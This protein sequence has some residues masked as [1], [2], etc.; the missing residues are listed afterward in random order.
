MCTFRRQE[1]LF[2]AL[3]DAVQRG[4]FHEAGSLLSQHK[5]ESQQLLSNPA[6]SARRQAQ[7]L[8]SMA[9]SVKGLSASD[10]AVLPELLRRLCGKGLS[11]L[12]AKG[13]GGGAALHAALRANNI[14]AVTALLDLGADPRIREGSASADGE[15]AGGSGGDLPLHLAARFVRPCPAPLVHQLCGKNFAL[16][17]MLSTGGNTAVHIALRNAN[18][19]TA[20]TLLERGADVNRANDDGD[21]PVHLVP[22]CIEPSNM[23][24]CMP[25]LRRLCGKDRL[26]LQAAGSGGCTPLHAALRDNRDTG[27]S[28]L[29]E[30]GASTSSRNARGDMAI[31]IAAACVRPCTVPLMRRLASKNMALLNLP[32]ADG[33]TPIHAALHANSP[34]AA[35]ALL[36]LSA[37]TSIRDGREDL[38][39]HLAASHV[40]PCNLPLLQRLA[41]KDLNERGYMGRT[42]LHAALAANNAT[43]AAW[44]IDFGADVSIRDQEGNLALHIGAMSVKPCTMALFRLLAGRGLKHL[45]VRGAQDCTP[46]QSSLR[47]NNPLAATILLD[48]GANE[49]VRDGQGNMPLHLAASFLQPCTTALLQ[50]LTGRGHCMLN[51][52]GANDRTA[53]SS[54]LK[55]ENAAA[56]AALMELG[57]EALKGSRWGKHCNSGSATPRG[58]FQHSMYRDIG[59]SLVGGQRV[60]FAR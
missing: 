58:I 29:L 15:A 24:E 5:L 43:A 44:L 39:L 40:K 59:A 49:T 23:R 51:T 18:P 46:L 60:G 27:A 20:A 38:P 14:S 54:A 42:A 25:L 31:H 21:F 26:L 7:R 52:H 57:T 47:A 2:D 11:L 19:M 30:L 16:L 6:E 33:K 10:R 45:N 35:A 1:R 56:A 32:G 55:A 50:R 28:A 4:A 3:Q 9:A 12:D 41:A 13:D 48:L 37:D 22:W 17:N 53:L 36:D 8:L 34:G